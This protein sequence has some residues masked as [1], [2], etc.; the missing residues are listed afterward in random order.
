MIYQRSEKSDKRNGILFTED[1]AN[2]FFGQMDTAGGLTSDQWEQ[3]TMHGFGQHAFGTRQ[4][5][6]T[7]R[8]ELRSF[9]NRRDF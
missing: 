2:A 1:F 8:A 6:V 3:N 5:V 4:G 7:A 9:C